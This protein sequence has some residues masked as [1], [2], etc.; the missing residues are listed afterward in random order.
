MENKN[1]K[2]V[3]LFQYFM[4][5]AVFA[6]A[7]TLPGYAAK[8]Q[9]ASLLKNEMSGAENRSEE[10]TEA[11]NTQ[12][13]VI[14]PGHG[15]DDPGMIGESGISEKVLN[16]IYAKK[17]AALLEA[18]GYEAV[19]TRTTEDGLYDA[20]ASNKKAQDMQRRVAIIEEEDPVLTVSIHQNSYPEDSSVKGPQV[21]YYE[22]SA[23]GEKLATAIQDS[24]N[25]ELEVER[26][27]VQ[28][29]NTTYYILKR[30]VSTTV[31][32]EC[33]FLTNPQEEALLQEETYQD[34]MAQAICDGILT[35]LLGKNEYN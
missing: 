10:M 31:I 27:R 32:V 13:I 1:S 21:F 26:P 24:L 3:K 25:E 14:D 2:G 5:L 12:T 4:V 11:Q 15:G 33:G 17:L 8:W 35:Y 6:A 23:E 18:E 20:D 9:A 28:K 16:L 34:R 7:L 22:Q 19:L 30:S 29:G